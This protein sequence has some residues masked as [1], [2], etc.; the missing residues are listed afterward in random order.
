MAGVPHRIGE[1]RERGRALTFAAPAA[2]DRLHQVERNLRLVAAVGLGAA[3]RRLEI[4]LTAAARQAARGRIMAVGISGDYLLFNP[5]AS[6]AARTFDPARH[7]AAARLLG[8]RSRLPVVMCGA[9]RDRP[10]AAALAGI[11]GD[12][13]VDL[14]GDTDLPTFAGLLAGAR[15]VLTNNTAALHLADAL[16]VPQLVTYAGTDLVSQWTPRASPHRLL[17]RDTACTPCYR[18]TCPFGHECLALPAEQL[19]AAG[20]A[21]LAETR[22]T[23]TF[24]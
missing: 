5:F 8:E 13:G 9:P 17:R 20:L 12:R 16:A 14:V 4:R 22:A 15:L 24:V 11:L 21:L 6:C 3:S 10:R 1:S 23:P 7:A 18:M 2:P 19:V